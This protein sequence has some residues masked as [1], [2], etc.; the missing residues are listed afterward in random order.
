MVRANSIRA[1]L[2]NRERT[3]GNGCWDVR[4]FLDPGIRSLTAR[5]LHQ[6]HVD[7]CCLSEV[8]NPYTGSREREI[9]EV[10]SHFTLYHSAPRDSS[11]RHSVVIALSEQAHRELRALEPFNDRMAFARLKGEFHPSPTY[12]VS[13]DPPSEG[14]DADAIQTLRDN[15]APEEDG[16]PTELY[17]A[18]VDSLTPWLHEVIEQVWRDEVVPYD[19]GSGSLLPVF[20]NGDK[21]KFQCES[22]WRIME[23]DGV[24]AK[25]IALIKALYRSNTA[26]SLY[27]TLGRGPT[28]R[29]FELGVDEIFT[30]R[31]ILEFHH[32]QQ[33]AWPSALLTPPM[34][35]IL[36]SLWRLMELDGMPAKIISLL[37]ALYRSTNAL[38]ALVSARL[39]VRV[40]R[41]LHRSGAFSLN[42]WN[43]TV[44][45]QYHPAMWLS[46]CF[47]SASPRCAISLLQR[48]TL[49]VKFADR[50]TTVT[51]TKTA[52]HLN[53][54]Q[55][56]EAAISQMQRQKLVQENSR[57]AGL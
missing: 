1:V 5:S 6:Y 37:K 40:L 49:P 50:T 11:G 38:N 41:R 47:A 52:V 34:R 33:L 56:M 51:T 46:G 54:K 43:T 10:N 21:T 39:G 25:I 14:E 44:P 15:K 13:C 9:L 8:R 24:P 48:S 31:R 55:S 35:S 18:C 42:H 36:S 22:V 28:K 12:T 20:K 32:G 29:D 2:L 23:L 4:I 19:C 26:F 57:P 3:L 7:V 45:V 30:L 27:V 16:K 53:A 17:N